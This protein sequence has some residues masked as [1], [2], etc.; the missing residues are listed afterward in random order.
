MYNSIE[1]NDNYSKTSQSLWHYYRDEQFVDDND[2]IA[3]F[4]ANNN[5]SGSFKFE[6]KIAGR[7]KNYGTKNFQIR[8]PFQYFSNFWRTFETP[9]I[10]CEINLLL[11][12]SNKLDSTIENQVP[13][14]TIT[15]RKLYV[16]DVTLS[17]QHNAK[18][19]EQLKL[20]FKRTINW[21]KYEL[22]VTVQQRMNI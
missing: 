4:I 17:S 11:T 19:L 13:T 15:D 2:A 7:T 8:V 20:G 14:F 6:T 3:D 18:L 5:N 22:K 1:Y 21:N 12:W 9:F 10:N 16:P